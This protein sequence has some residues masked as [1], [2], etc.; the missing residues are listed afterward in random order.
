MFIKGG[1]RCLEGVFFPKCKTLPMLWGVGGDIIYLF[2][3][4][5]YILGSG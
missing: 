5:I 1:A 2:S 4:I 3:F